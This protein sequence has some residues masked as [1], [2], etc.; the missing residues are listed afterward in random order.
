MYNRPTEIRRRIYL[1]IKTFPE[2]R[3]V[4]LSHIQK[5][6]K[7]HRVTPQEMGFALQELKEKRAI[8]Y[9]PKRGWIAR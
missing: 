3:N 7:V 2:G 6:A 4:Y 1:F 9:N 8:F 5:F